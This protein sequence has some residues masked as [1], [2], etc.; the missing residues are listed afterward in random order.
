MVVRKA[1]KMAQQMGVPVLGIVENMSYFQI[2]DSDNRIEIFGPS[3]AAAMAKTVGAPILG[4]IP[5]D[6]E[7]ARLC[8]KGEIE[9]YDSDVFKE[10][11]EAI[12]RVLSL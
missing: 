3:Q 1:V 8:D 7:L 2:P 4:K 6:P 9:K 12:T 10:M 11:S 5:L